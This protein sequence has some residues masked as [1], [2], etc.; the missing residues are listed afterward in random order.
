MSNTRDR[1]VSNRRKSKINRWIRFLKKDGDWDCGYLI[2]ME[3]M[4]LAQMEAHFRDIDTFVGVESVRRDLRL[5]LRLLDIILETDDLQIELSPMKMTAFRE[6]GK[7]M[8]RMEGG[9]EVLSY[10]KIYVN[11]RNASRFVSY[12]PEQGSHSESL[13]LIYRED[14]RKTKAW[15]LYNKIRAYRMFTWWE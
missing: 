6:N 12:E 14:L 8:Y 2:E 4:K 3:R 9:G 5:S 11:T 7:R 10:R 15:F 13:R 1:S